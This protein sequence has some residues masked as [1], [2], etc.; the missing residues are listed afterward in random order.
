MGDVISRH[1]M[2]LPVPEDR[3]QAKSFMG[4]IIGEESNREGNREHNLYEMCDVRCMV[5]H[6]TGVGA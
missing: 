1:D 3:F 5:C 4:K 2:I 6:R